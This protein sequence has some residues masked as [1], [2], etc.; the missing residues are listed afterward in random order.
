VVVWVS[1]DDIEPAEAEGMKCFLDVW[2]A[3]EVI[4]NKARRSGLPEP[5]IDEQVALLIDY[6]RTGA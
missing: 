6:A 1:E 4:E 3:K 5:T 2:H